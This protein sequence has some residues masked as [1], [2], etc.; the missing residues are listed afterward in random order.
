MVAWRGGR[1]RVQME[2]EVTAVADLRA[3]LP[4]CLWSSGTQMASGSQPCS[5][6]RRGTGVRRGSQ[7]SAA[8]AEA[9]GGRV[10]LGAGVFVHIRRRSLRSLTELEG[11]WRVTSCGR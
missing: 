7:A 6:S 11:M 5:R 9:D 3:F 8:E 1:W 10:V 4:R 2:G